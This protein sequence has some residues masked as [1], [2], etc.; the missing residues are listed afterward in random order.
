MKIKER[1]IKKVEALEDEEKLLQLEQWLDT[2]SSRE[3][4]EMSGNPAH[5]PEKP[6]NKEGSG[7]FEGESH[8]GGDKG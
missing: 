5:Q 1:I 4:E 8:T 2:N 3:S 6:S 7:L